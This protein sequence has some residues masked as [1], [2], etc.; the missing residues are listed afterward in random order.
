MHIYI[1]IHKL[2]FI[3]V[4]WAGPN[5]NMSELES[6]CMYGNGAC[7]DTDAATNHIVL[8]HCHMSF[9]SLFLQR[10]APFKKRACQVAWD[11]GAII[12]TLDVTIINSLITVPTSMKCK[13][14]E[15]QFGFF[16][17]CTHSC[18]HLVATGI[19]NINPNEGLTCYFNNL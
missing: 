15:Y 19:D 16:Q 17:T 11:Q 8:C 4:Y 7:K 2:N 3:F 10:H 5:K 9:C 1:I 14:G 13:Q 18:G 6:L 12:Q